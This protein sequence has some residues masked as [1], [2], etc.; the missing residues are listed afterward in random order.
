MPCNCSL[1]WDNCS[2]CNASFLCPATN[3]FQSLTGGFRVFTEH[4]F[5]LA[6][7][8]IPISWWLWVWFHIK[9][10]AVHQGDMAF[11]VPVDTCVSIL[12]RHSMSINRILLHDLEQWL[13]ATEAD[14]TELVVVPLLIVYV[15]NI[16]ILVS[17][18]CISV[19]IC[20]VLADKN[21]EPDYGVGCLV[22]L[23]IDTVFVVWI[24]QLFLKECF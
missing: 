6:D 4:G 17:T 3:L 2:Y 15:F 22:F 1:F 11:S 10:L 16:A 24:R 13:V 14:W 21:T 5:C 19:K 18:K 9:D 23:A 20:A 12:A 7:S 8:L